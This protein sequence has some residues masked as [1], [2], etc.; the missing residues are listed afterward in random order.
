[1]VERGDEEGMTHVRVLATDTV[2]RTKDDRVRL[3]REVLAFAETL[4]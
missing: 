1:V 2:M 3:A 4:V